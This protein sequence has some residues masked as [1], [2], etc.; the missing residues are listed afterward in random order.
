MRHS[1]QGTAMM[2]SRGRALVRSTRRGHGANL[3]RIA[4]VLAITTAVASTTASADGS[5]SASGSTRAVL[6]RIAAPVETTTFRATGF[7]PAAPRGLLLWRFDGERYL[8]LAET[9]SG[10]DG[11][12]D[13]GLQPL[14]LAHADFGVTGPDDSPVASGLQSVER[15]L[16]APIVTAHD[17]GDGDVLRVLTAR[18]EGELYLSD[19]AT[20]RLLAR[21]PVDSTPGHALAID[22]ATALPRVRPEAIAI[23][24]VLQDGRRSAPEI[25]LLENPNER[26]SD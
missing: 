10:D 17:S 13:F 25:W 11:R 1:H 22:L 6:D 20:G 26:R 14:P 24:H 23:E 3:R 4:G 16:P 21:I 5:A 19:A 7:D 2:G 8:R 18:A 9:R 15:R 12:F